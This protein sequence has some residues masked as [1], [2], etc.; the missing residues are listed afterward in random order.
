MMYSKS[1]IE[2]AKNR[3]AIKRTR[4]LELRKKGFSMTEIRVI[5][6]K[7]FN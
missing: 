6:H 4:R 1:E 5:I 7:E 3:V 2:N